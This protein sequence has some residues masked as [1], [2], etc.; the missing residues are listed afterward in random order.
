MQNQYN[1]NM[2]E[3]LPAEFKRHIARYTSNELSRVLSKRLSKRLS[4]LRIELKDINII[5]NLADKYDEEY[6]LLE[7]KHD[8]PK[9]IEYFKLA[10]LL[11]AAKYYLTNDINTALYEYYHSF[12]STENAIADMNIA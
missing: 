9:S 12:E 10:R 5:S 8:I 11:S 4:L 6:F 3:G 7:E 1:R 2:T